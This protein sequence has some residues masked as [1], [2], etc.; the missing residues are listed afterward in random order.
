MLIFQVIVQY[1]QL[2]II[3]H[4]VFQ[5]LLH[6]KWNLFGKLGSAKMLAL[7]FLYTIIWTILGILIPRDHKYY[8]PFSDNW[9]RLI[10]EI[11]GV[12]MTIYFIFMVRKFSFEKVHIKLRK[13]LWLRS[14]D[15]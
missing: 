8:Q 13:H 3:M 1:D 5:R 4:P 15:Y 11:F 2:D 7:N 12:S 6:V 9:W 14:K 10:L